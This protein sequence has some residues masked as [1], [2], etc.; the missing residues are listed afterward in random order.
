MYKEILYHSQSLNLNGKKF[1][2]ETVRAV[3]IK[4]SRILLIYSPIN[5]DYKFPGGGIEEPETHELSL[6]REIMEE[7]GMIK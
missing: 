2:R 7:C 1:Y 6:K 5:G 3:L 4:D